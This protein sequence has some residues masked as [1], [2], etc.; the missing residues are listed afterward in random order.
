VVLSK[1]LVVGA[2]DFTGRGRL[3]IEDSVVE[4]G[5]TSPFAIVA[6]TDGAVL[7]VQRS[8]ITWASTEKPQG[9]GAIQVLA[10]ARVIAIG[11]DISGTGDGIQLA[12]DESRIVGNR[13]HGLSTVAGMHN[14][15][16]QIF[17]GRSIVLESNDIEVPVG[18]TGNAGIFV[19]LGEGA[20]VTD[21]VVE[22]N[23]LHGGGYGLVLEG[24]RPKVS[25]VVVTGNVFSGPHQ[26]G[27]AS[28]TDPGAVITWT[29]NEDASHAWVPRP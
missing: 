5:R 26:W 29:N 1:L 11:N 7:R 14:D 17:N 21:L 2:I 16:V 9:N 25:D 24:G 8:T 3:T 15:G 28:L 18:P 6:R 27:P 22:R 10:K 12:A 4:A 20:D 23:T 13:I 19:Q